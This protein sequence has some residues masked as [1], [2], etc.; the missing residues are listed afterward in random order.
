M[1]Y[2]NFLTGWCCILTDDTHFQHLNYFSILDVLN[3]A[4]TKHKLKNIYR[5]KHWN[6]FKKHKIMTGLSH[7]S[8][9]SSIF[10]EWQYLTCFI[11]GNT[12]KTAH[13]SLVLKQAPFRSDVLRNGCTAPHILKSD[14]SVNKYNHYQLIKKVY[15][16]MIII[17]SMWY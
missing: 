8:V 6:K 5:K 14:T 12:N 4:N 16:Y 10:S 13:L 15:L 3:V 2:T 1:T 11:L 17:A 7:R 9:N